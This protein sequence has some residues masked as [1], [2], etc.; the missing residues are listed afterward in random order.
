MISKLTERS[1]SNAYLFLTL[2]MLLWAGNHVIGRWAAG[3]IPP[4][5]LAFLR[6]AGAALIVLPLAW[7]SLERDRTAIVGNW[8]ILLILGL[9]GSGCYNTLQYIALNETTV[10]NAAIINSWAPV[11]IAGAA[12]ALFGDQLSARQISGLALSLA[13]VAVIILRGDSATLTQMAF[14]RG[15]LVMVLA[16]AIW[17]AYTT[18]LRFRPAIS[19]LS[20]AAV[21]YTIAAVTNLPLALYEYADGQRIVETWAALCA[22]AYTAVFASL[23]AYYLYARS[24]EIIGGTRTGAFIHLIPLF[25]SAMGLVFLGETPEAYHAAGF[26]LILSGVWLA[27]R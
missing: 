16:T 8:R 17:A 24:V 1:T 22:I 23:V 18:L 13:G 12:A 9:L 10:A 14:N 2:T 21:T 26:G 11:L 15:D 19:T 3:N 4:M 7:P 5:T 25:A 6:W 20:F 27:A